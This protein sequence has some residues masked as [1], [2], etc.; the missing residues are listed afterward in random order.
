MFK[1]EKRGTLGYE[2]LMRQ[3]EAFEEELM[4]ENPHL[5]MNLMVLET[6]LRERFQRMEKQVWDR[7]SE[8]SL[9]DLPTDKDLSE[10]DIEAM[11]PRDIVIFPPDMDLTGSHKRKRTLQTIGMA[12]ALAVITAIGVFGLASLLQLTISWL[13]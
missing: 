5:A 6:K 8:L 13:A 4:E 10:S 3:L 11:I 12:A 1:V 2:D 9:E 7:Y